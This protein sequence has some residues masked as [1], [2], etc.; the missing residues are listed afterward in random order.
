MST[1]DTLLFHAV[2]EH[3]NARVT[4]CNQFL[5]DSCIELRLLITEPVIHGV[6]HVFICPKLASSQTF[7]QQQEHIPLTSSQQVLNFPCSIWIG[8]HEG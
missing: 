7:L 4:A 8:T 6:F 2:I 5:Q 3:I 1:F